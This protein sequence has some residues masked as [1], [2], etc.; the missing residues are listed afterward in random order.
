MRR[1]TQRHAATAIVMAAVVAG[2]TL[3]AAIRAMADP[4][5]PRVTRS[6]VTSAG[7]GASSPSTGDTTADSTAAPAPALSASPPAS[8]G[9]LA[10]GGAAP[11]PL[12]PHRSW[13]RS[14]LRPDRLQHA[15]LS[16]TLG[17]SVG[18][19]AR[20]PGAG[21]A[22]GMS[23]GVAKELYDLHRTGFDPG[24]LA[25]DALGVVTAALCVAAL[26]H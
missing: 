11:P 16:L 12:V 15:S 10:A 9:T 18:F 21:I 13:A 4:D 8:V 26:D 1:R 3:L 2:V 6:V 24:D 22:A 23:A 17:L 7:D 5:A 25:A 14:V 19:L 20:S